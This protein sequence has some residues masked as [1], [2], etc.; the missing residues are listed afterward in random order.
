MHSDPH[1][2][3]DN[4]DKSYGGKVHPTTFDPEFQAPLPR[5]CHNIVPCPRSAI[6]DHPC[7]TT[8]SWSEARKHLVI[9]ARDI[10]TMVEAQAFVIEHFKEFF[11][12]ALVESEELKVQ[13]PAGTAF[14][15]MI[16]EDG[17][18]RRQECGRSDRPP[19]PNAMM[20]NL[21]DPGVAP[22]WR[23]HNR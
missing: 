21:G 19:W 8:S 7:P 3:E 23:P 18:G 9:I 15:R 22:G 5:V 12:K 20:Q 16:A 13:L 6:G 17:R 11:T 10:A 1:A 4:A 2:Q 14:T